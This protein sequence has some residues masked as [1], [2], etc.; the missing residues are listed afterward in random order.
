MHCVLYTGTLMHKI[1]AGAI[2]LIANCFH[3]FHYC[4]LG[5]FFNVKQICS[6]CSCQFFLR[7]DIMPSEPDVLY[8]LEL[9]EPPQELLDWAKENIRENPDTRCLII[10]D[11]RDMIYGKVD[12]SFS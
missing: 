8:E 12:F 10:E 4:T 11:F 1:V 2:Q 6:S 9:G 3:A 5:G 7:A